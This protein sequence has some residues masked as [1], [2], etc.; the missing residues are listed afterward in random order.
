M[1]NPIEVTEV[2]AFE[3]HEH[4]ALDVGRLKDQ[5]SVL[6]DSFQIG[7]EVLEDEI[8]VRFGREDVEELI[9][10]RSMMRRRRQGEGRASTTLGCLSS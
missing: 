4:P 1:Q 5:V 3:G 6:D 9:D 7:V 10:L 2:E 8:E